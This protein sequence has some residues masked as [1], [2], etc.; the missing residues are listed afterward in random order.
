MGGNCCELTVFTR[1][2]TVF[3]GFPLDILYGYSLYLRLLAL[4]Y[5]C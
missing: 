2:S 4:T 5:W 3:Y 1:V